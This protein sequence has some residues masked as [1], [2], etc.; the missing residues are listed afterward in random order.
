MHARYT[1][2]SLWIHSMRTLP[3]SSVLRGVRAPVIASIV[4]AFAMAALNAVTHFNVPCSRPHTLLSWALALLLVFRTNSSY[5]RFWEGRKIWEKLLNRSRDLVR[6]STVYRG[7]IGLRR[8]RRIA[9]LVTAMPGA[10]R[11][12]MRGRPRADGARERDIAEC[13]LPYDRLVL[14]RVRN[15]AL[16]IDF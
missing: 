8:L 12:H 7:A 11:E 15:R 16:F 13:L 6:M 14:A 10:L 2:S 4:W 9:C 1:T 3:S 5:N